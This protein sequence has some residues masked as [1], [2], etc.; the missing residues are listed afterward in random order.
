MLL[1][2]KWCSSD[3]VKIIMKYPESVTVIDRNL[4]EL[5]TSGVTGSCENNNEIIQKVLYNR[6]QPT[7]ATEKW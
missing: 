2:E 4:P 6:P 7:Q 3:V 5:P 1:T